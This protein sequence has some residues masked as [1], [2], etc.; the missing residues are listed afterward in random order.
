MST[1]HVIIPWKCGS[2][3]VNRILIY[4]ANK[5][6]FN[7]TSLDN[8]KQTVK[9]DDADKHLIF[10]RNPKRFV[11]LKQP[12]HTNV[13]K[14]IVLRHPLSRLISQYYSFGWT[15]TTDAKWI[16][17]REQRRAKRLQLEK[18]QK[19][20]RSMKID[21]Y[22]ARELGNYIDQYISDCLSDVES[23]GTV[24]LPYELLIQQ[25]TVFV[26]KVLNLIEE[27]D[28]LNQVLTEFHKDFQPV[29]DST[30]RILTEG[31]RTHRRSSDVHEW[32]HR[33]NMDYINQQTNNIHNDY[34]EQYNEF[35]K[36]WSNTH[37]HSNNNRKET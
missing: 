9:F 22:V 10:S 28:S 2:S 13:N 24:I 26:N 34:I 16:T 3:L 17:N 15:H 21:D 12:P 4:V 18:D 35:L 33:L 8:V 36:L 20:I 14:L 31:Y 11:N 37:T 6:K 25:P 19:D 7:Y 30:N 5:S 27:T 23:P 32:K 1:T 29:E